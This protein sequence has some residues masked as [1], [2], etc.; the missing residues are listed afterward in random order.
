[1]VLWEA[2]SV[3]LNSVFDL[4][5]D[6]NIMSIPPKGEDEANKAKIVERLKM[7]LF[8]GKVVIIFDDNKVLIRQYGDQ[9]IDDLW[10]VYYLIYKTFLNYNWLFPEQ[11][12]V[13]DIPEVDVVSFK[14][15][16]YVTKHVEEGGKTISYIDTEPC[17]LVL[18][19]KDVEDY[20]EA[21][22]Q[23]LLYAI[24]YYL[25][26]CNTQ[27]YFLVEF[28]KCME[29][30]KNH[31]KNEKE[32]KDVLQ[33]HGFLYTGYKKANI[34][35]NDSKKPLSI[36]RHAPDKGVSI[37]NIDTK[38][39]FSDP[40]GRKVFE[41]GEKACRNIIDSYIQFRIAIKA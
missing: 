7:A 21:I 19:K 17:E 41:I 1:M 27:Q 23:A 36:A 30:I 22:D 37:H 32:M 25:R 29:T 12:N 14:L 2:H 40:I 38:W 5:P 24:C 8:E 16:R 26:G 20:F 15:H 35:A 11:E 10:V 13:E 18:N 39:L 4:P 28:Y 31:F 6:R 34:F 33:P 3:I 9:Q